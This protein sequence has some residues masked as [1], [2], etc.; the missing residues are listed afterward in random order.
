[1]HPP[2]RSPGVEVPKARLKS[3]RSAAMPAVL[4]GAVEPANG[5]DGEAPARVCHCYFGHHLDHLR[6]QSALAQGVPIGSGE[7][8]SA[9]RDVVQKRLKRLGA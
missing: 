7:I 6:Y 9:N 4:R 5:S 1:V 3:D 2:I 8:E